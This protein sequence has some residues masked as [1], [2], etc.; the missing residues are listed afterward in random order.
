[1]D[2]KTLERIFTAHGFSF[3]LTNISKPE[4]TDFKVLIK[5]PVV[6]VASIKYLTLFNQASMAIMA[7]QRYSVPVPSQD[8]LE[9]CGKKGIR[10]KNAGMM[11]VG[12]PL[13]RTGWR[14]PHVGATAS[15]IIQLHHKIQNDDGTVSSG[16]GL[17]GLS[18]IKGR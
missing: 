3:S 14:P 9:G 12:A 10:R 5:L 16:T 4:D 7:S 18:R 11:E 8:K 15:I 13:L 17:P 6:A 2:F 1:V